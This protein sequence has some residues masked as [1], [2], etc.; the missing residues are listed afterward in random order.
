M[1]QSILVT[2]GAGFLGSHLVHALASKGERVVVYDN[3][4]AGLPANLLDISDR[5]AIVNGDTL[6]LNYLLQ[7]MLKNEVNR[8]IHTAALVSFPV[9]VEK[10]ALTAKVN[11]EGTINLLDASRIVGVKRYLDVSSEETYGTFQYEPADEDHPLSPTQP[12]AITKMA[13]ERYEDFYRRYFGLDV[14]II[15]TSWVY[16]PGLPRNRAP[17]SFIE[18]SLKGLPT[19][20]D[21]GADHRVDHTYIDDFVQ[22]ALLAFEARQPQSRIFHIASG[23][24]HTFREM[25]QMVAE[26]IPGADITVG[27]GLIKY[28]PDVLAPQKGALNVDRARKELGYQPRTMLFEGL[29]KYTDFLRKGN[30][31]DVCTGKEGEGTARKRV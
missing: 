9:C 6:D 27:P 16:G 1:S 25:A 23:Q 11:I 15:R 12:Y 22:G 17:K 18:N 31:G 29:K 8:V 10:P 13:A 19:Q 28:S 4:S 3:F 7:T 14:V 5:L 26:I 20:M 24:A 30:G 21:S 2:G